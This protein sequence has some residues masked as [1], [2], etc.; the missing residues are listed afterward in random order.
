MEKLLRLADNPLPLPFGR[1]ENQRSLISSQSLIDAVMTIIERD[2]ASEG[3]FL[4]HD[5]AVSSARLIRLLR[6]GLARPER[7]FA[8]P[9]YVWSISGKLPGLGSKLDR[10]TR[11]LV[12]DD[13][14]FRRTYNW[15]PDKSID[16]LL[17]EFARD[18][19]SRR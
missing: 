6:R 19:K 5:D 14:K 2:D 9:R 3:V 17:M 13:Q 15:Q 4:V 11:S 1:L 18:A 7:L 10:F 16:T 8:L 12:L